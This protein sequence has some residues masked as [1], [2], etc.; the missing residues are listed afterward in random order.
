MQ[1]SI[2]GTE[3][4]IKVENEKNTLT[5]GGALSS[6]V[7][8]KPMVTLEN[9][10]K[11]LKE[12]NNMCLQ[13]KT[14][15][16]F[17]IVTV[18]LFGIVAISTSVLVSIY[19]GNE[20]FITVEHLKVMACISTISLGILTAF[21]LVSNANNARNAWKS[22]NSAIMFYDAGI[23]T[24]QQLIEQYR[25]GEDQLGNL[26]FNYGANT[27]KAGTYAYDIATPEERKRNKPNLK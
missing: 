15:S 5:I 6:T 3:P 19:T 18:S 26:S 27:D 13:W 24:I 4:T 10:G 17:Y 16:I 9:E 25:K 7:A 14:L 2:N 1:S 20:Q 21:N 11:I 12:I 8:E 22:L 23:I